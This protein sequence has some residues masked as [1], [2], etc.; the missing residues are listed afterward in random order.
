MSFAAA[1]AAT[2]VLEEQLPAPSKLPAE[3]AGLAGGAAA[4][5]A[6]AAAAE[7]MVSGV[8]QMKSTVPMNPLWM[9]V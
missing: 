9:E 8:Y 7:G 3:A 5:A 1:S 4:A 2:A 6:V